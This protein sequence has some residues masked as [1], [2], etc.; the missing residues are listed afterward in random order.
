M[1]YPGVRS[2]FD[3]FVAGL[4]LPW[5]RY[6]LWLFEKA[7]REECGYKGYLP[8]WNWP[9]WAGN[10]HESPLFDGS[11]TS[12][13]GDGEY[14]PGEE[15]LSSGAVTILRGSGGGC[16]RRGPFK[17]IT[18]HFGPFPRSLLSATE[19]PAPRFDYNPRCL[20]RSLNSFVSTH[21]T[22]Q[23]QVTRLLAAKNI[24]DFQMVMDH[25]PAAP[26]GVLG[27]HGGGHFSIGS[28]MQDLFSSPQDPAFMLHHAMIDRLW[29]I[30]Q[31]EDEG[32]RR[33]AVNGT[34]RI[35][36]APTAV[37]VSLD[38][39]MEFGVLDGNRMVGE[40]MSP[41]ESGLCYAYT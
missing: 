22:S 7:L 20:N 13:S 16:V 33:Y 32:N 35:L 14:N 5:H 3:D 1:E 24:A 19:I 17:D 26:D 29:A 40:V 21:F 10:L 4:F 8:Y 31:A 6:F 30:W 38:M 15:S 41:V 34:N 27:L 2:R 36:N 12:L 25:W 11:E 39:Q 9:L 37:L 28:T 23:T 18:I